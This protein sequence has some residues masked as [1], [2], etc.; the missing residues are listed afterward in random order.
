MDKT[1]KEISVS[2]LLAYWHDARESIRECLRRTPDEL[3]GWRP[4]DDMRTFGEIY[5][6]IANSIDSWLTRYV[7]DGG[8]W[9]PS[10]Q[11]PTTDRGKLDRHLV[12]SFARLGKYAMLTNTSLTCKDK[13]GQDFSG[14]WLLLHLFEHDIHHRGQ[15]KT[16]L[17]LNGIAPPVEK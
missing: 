4:K 17:R 5:V 10:A 6:H 15:L 7:K 11:L 16:Y 14:N 13:D 8:E 2:S 3:L 12:A 9:I 1:V